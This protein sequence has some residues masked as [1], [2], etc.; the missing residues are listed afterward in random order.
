MGLLGIPAPHNTLACLP[1]RA[2]D[3]PRAATL[4]RKDFEL[5]QYLFLAWH[6]GNTD[7]RIHVCMKKCKIFAILS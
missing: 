3:V 5:P 6:R 2:F 7:A 1:L 4:G